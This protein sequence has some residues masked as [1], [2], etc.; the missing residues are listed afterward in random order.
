V[1]EEEEQAAEEEEL[2]VVVAVDRGKQTGFGGRLGLATHDS[3][4]GQ[5]CLVPML[6]QS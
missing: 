4:A 6:I 5:S 2:V 3:T 1:E